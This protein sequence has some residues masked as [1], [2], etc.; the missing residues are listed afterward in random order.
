MTCED[1]GKTGRGDEEPRLPF[2]NWVYVSSL[3]SRSFSPLTRS[4]YQAGS[5]HGLCTTE[6]FFD[7]M[8]P[9]FREK[10]KDDGIVNYWLHVTSNR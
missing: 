1:D 5:Q 8:L 6:C 4:S 2:F 10:R 3:C 7:R 9:G